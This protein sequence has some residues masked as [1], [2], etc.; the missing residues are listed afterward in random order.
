MMFVKGDLCPI[1]LI[2]KE[3]SQ[4]W[5]LLKVAVEKVTFQDIIL[6]AL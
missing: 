1:C 2:L 5:D 6:N 3:E 4:L